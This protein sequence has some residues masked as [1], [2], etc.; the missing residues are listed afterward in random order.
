ENFGEESS[1]LI[2]QLNDQSERGEWGSLDFSTMGSGLE[3]HVFGEDTESIQEAAEAILPILE[4]EKDL[5]HVE[6][7]I[8][9]AYDQY[10]LVADQKKLSKEG[11]N[12]AP[13]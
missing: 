10:T 1:E 12:A 11:L 9:D 6:S 13:V 3:L 5:E 4:E 7:S 8:T 2:A